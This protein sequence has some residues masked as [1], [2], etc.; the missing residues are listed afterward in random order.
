VAAQA[1]A[2]GFAPFYWDNGDGVINR[3]NNTVLDQ[4]SL[5]SMKVGV[6]LQ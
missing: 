1:A 3:T 4:Q 5:D 6:G 2:N